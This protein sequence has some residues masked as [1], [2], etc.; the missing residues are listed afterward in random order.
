[1][2][3]LARHWVQKGLVQHPREIVNTSIQNELL[4]ERGPS[5]KKSKKTPPPAASPPQLRAQGL[6]RGAYK[7]YFR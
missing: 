1:M 6:L 2:V 7:S 5:A 4:A 3:D